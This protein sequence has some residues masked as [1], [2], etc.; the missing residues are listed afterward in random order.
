MAKQR[1]IVGSPLTPALLKELGA[2]DTF[3]QTP[4]D[5]KPAEDWVN[6]Y[7]IWTCHGYR[8]S[9]N[10]NVGFLRIQKKTAREDNTFELHTEQ[11][12]LQTD[13]MLNTIKTQI[14]CLDNEYASPVQWTLS[15]HFTGPTGKV[16]GELNTTENVSIKGMTMTIETPAGTLHRQVDTPL[17]SD[18]SLF[19]AAQRWDV[20]EARH[21]RMTM[22]EGLHALKPEQHITYRGLS[23]M[24][25]GSGATRLF[26]FAQLGT[27]ILPTEYW[28]DM[29]HRLLVVTSMNKAYILDEQAEAI[30][31]RDLE[32][33][34][35]SYRNKASRRK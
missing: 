27:G 18:W 3:P 12:V 5:F 7:R 35:K 33:A 23:Q 24:G 30:F 10:E 15:S 9:G 1:T 28:L 8:E 34:Q 4:G 16:L 20:G 31:A 26:R 32:R 6:T 21:L 19:E 25:D 11:A 14:T 2:V 22:L 13:A 17:T 29:S